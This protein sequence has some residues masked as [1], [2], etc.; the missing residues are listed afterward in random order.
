MPGLQSQENNLV[1]HQPFDQDLQHPLAQHS[2]TFISSA[3]SNIYTISPQCHATDYHS[4]PSI[5]WHYP[6]DQHS[7]TSIRSALTNSHQI[8]I[9]QH[10]QDH[11]SVLSYRL[12]L[13]AI[14][15]LAIS[16]KSARSSVHPV[17][18]TCHP[19]LGDIQQI[20]TKFC[21]SS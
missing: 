5:T 3:L 4:V 15:R 2:P 14:H 19:S 21:P 8:S 20:S 17:S 11:S 9:Q 7:P 13:S 6:L 10:L 16:N 12:P 1:K 18:S